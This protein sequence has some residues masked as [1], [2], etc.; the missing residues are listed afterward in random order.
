MS[1]QQLKDAVYKERVDMTSFQPLPF[2]YVEVCFENAC[3]H[4]RVGSRMFTFC[5]N[6]PNSQPSTG[7]SDNGIKDYSEIQQ[8]VLKI[9]HKYILF[10]ETHMLGLYPMYHTYSY[11]IQFPVFLVSKRFYLSAQL[12]HSCR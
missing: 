1:L 7:K 9:F 11:F 8:Y 12:G 4:R 5:T 10:P 2:H 6:V 3:M